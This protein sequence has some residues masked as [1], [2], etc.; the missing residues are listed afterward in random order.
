MVTRERN[1][2]KLLWLLK[3]NIYFP[4]VFVVQLIP[5][6]SVGLVCSHVHVC[7][8]GKSEVPAMLLVS[9]ILCADAARKLGMYFLHRWRCTGGKSPFVTHL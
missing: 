3:V 9:L 1:P 2:T 6:G 4:R 8:G 5:A 7:G